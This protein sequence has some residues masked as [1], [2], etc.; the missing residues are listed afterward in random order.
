MCVYVGGG[1]QYPLPYLSAV[2]S[3]ETKPFG[4]GHHLGFY[5]L[6]VSSQHLHALSNLLPDARDTKEDGRVNFLHG[7]DNQKK[8]DKIDRIYIHVYQHYLITQVPI[9]T[10]A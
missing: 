6:G 4:P 9:T 8:R 10:I 1:Y 3:P 2:V 5:A 7:L